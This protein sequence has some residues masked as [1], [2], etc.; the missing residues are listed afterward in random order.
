MPLSLHCCTPLGHGRLQ[1]D[2]RVGAGGLLVCL[3]GLGPG[4]GLSSLAIMKAVVPS[5]GALGIL[6]SETKNRQDGWPVARGFRFLRCRINMTGA[7]LR[8]W[9]RGSIWGM[10]LGSSHELI[11]CEWQL[12]SFM[13]LRNQNSSKID[14]KV[15]LPCTHCARSIC[16]LGPGSFRRGLQDGQRSCEVQLAVN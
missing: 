6:S 4:S 5:T 12:P 3:Y 14:C 16:L 15:A 10:R 13:S 8:V 11:G 9:A 2:C 7:A 1:N